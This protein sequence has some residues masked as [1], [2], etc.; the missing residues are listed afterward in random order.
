MIHIGFPG[1]EESNNP[2]HDLAQSHDIVG[3]SN[4]RLEVGQISVPFGLQEGRTQDLTLAGSKYHWRVAGGQRPVEW[5]HADTRECNME[6]ELRIDYH[7]CMVIL[8]S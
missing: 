2:K 8:Q 4:E 7:A 1:H 6:T 3:L 5:T